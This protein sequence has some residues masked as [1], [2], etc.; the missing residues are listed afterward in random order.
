MHKRMKYYNVNTSVS[1][2]RIRQNGVESNALSVNYINPHI[3][4]SYIWIQCCVYGCVY[5]SKAYDNII[6]PKNENQNII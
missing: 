6:I 3:E 5:L 4:N 1:V 2:K